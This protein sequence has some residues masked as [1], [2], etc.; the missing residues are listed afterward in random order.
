MT[1]VMNIAGV[2]AILQSITFT[3]QLSKVLIISDL[4][5]GPDILESIPT[6]ILNLSQELFSQPSSHLS[7]PKAM[8]LTASSV[9]FTS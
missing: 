3:P 9:R 1:V 7:I 2:V 8:A 6:A 4:I 5:F